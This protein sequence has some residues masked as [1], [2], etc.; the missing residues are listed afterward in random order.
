VLVVEIAAGVLLG[1]LAYRGIDSYCTNRNLTLTAAILWNLRRLLVWTA[2]FAVVAGLGFVLYYLLTHP[3][4]LSDHEYAA[5]IGIVIFTTSVFLFALRSDIREGRKYKVV[6][7]RTSCDKCGEMSLKFTG[8]KDGYKSN[9]GSYDH[10]KAKCS[11]CGH[12]QML[13]RHA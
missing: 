5:F 4:W 7:A 10:P 11:G 9:V 3:R 2:V 6:A 1:L 13:L 12:E 8:F